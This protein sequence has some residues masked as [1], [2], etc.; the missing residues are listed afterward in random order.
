MPIYPIKFRILKNHS[1]ILHK[2]SCS[3]TAKIPVYIQH[4][5]IF[6][7]FGSDDHEHAGGYRIKCWPVDDDRRRH[8][9]ELSRARTLSSR[10]WNE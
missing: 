1:L 9:A 2:H 4:F 3:L 6:Q 8:R 7:S 10:A 5:L